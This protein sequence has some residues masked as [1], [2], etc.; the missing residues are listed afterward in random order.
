MKRITDARHFVRRHP[1]QDGHDA[2]GLRGVFE[3]H[4][5][6]PAFLAMIA[7]PFTMACGSP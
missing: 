2:A 3:T 1:A 5:M 7:S 4:H 6:I